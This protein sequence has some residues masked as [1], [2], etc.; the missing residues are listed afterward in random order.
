MQK[1]TPVLQI[2]QA[3]NFVCTGTDCEDTCCSGWAIPVDKITLEKW[4]NHPK[5]PSIKHGLHIVDNEKSTPAC[6]AHLKQ[7]QALQRSYPTCVFLDENKLCSLQNELSHDFLSHT[8]RKYPRVESSID[9]I[10]E[11][12]LDLSCPE[13]A[14]LQLKEKKGLTLELV[15]VVEE[16]GPFYKAITVNEV[17]S[18]SI[19]EKLH[20]RM[21]SLK[22]VQNRNFTISNRLILLGLFAHSLQ[23]AIQENKEIIPFTEEFEAFLNS[24]SDLDVLQLFD[25]PDSFQHKVAFLTLLVNTIKPYAKRHAVYNSY[26]SKWIEGISYNETNNSI[27]DIAYENCRQKF[28]AEFSFDYIMENYLFVKVFSEQFPILNKP[29]LEEFFNIALSYCLIREHIIGQYQENT[30]VDEETV[31]KIIQSYS[32]NHEHTIELQMKLHSILKDHKIDSLAH[33]CILIKD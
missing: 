32:R 13:S 30:N 12:S 9:G 17:N 21:F 4:K 10:N 11:M 16:P 8:C 33:F 29:I 3:L 1:K 18:L 5:F 6:S 20:L 2:S 19:E 15:E 26:F 28:I 23:N 14:R 31:I 27:Y 22:I 24:S 7:E 25:N